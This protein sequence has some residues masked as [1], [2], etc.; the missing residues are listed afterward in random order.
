MNC[1]DRRAKLSPDDIR[2]IR[3]CIEERVRLKRQARELSNAKLAHKFQVHRNTI[4][5]ISRECGDEES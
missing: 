1:P 4:V 2:I 3:Q 5:A